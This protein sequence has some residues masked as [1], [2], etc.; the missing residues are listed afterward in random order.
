[1][2]PTYLIIESNENDSYDK[3]YVDYL[4]EVEYKSSPSNL[5]NIPV[6]EKELGDSA[7]YD[8]LGGYVKENG[9]AASHQVP[10]GKLVV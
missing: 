6:S 2:P 8:G 3:D 5:L 4:L 9:N 1:M 7:Y 10:I